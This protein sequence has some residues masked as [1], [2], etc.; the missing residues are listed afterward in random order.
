M[1]FV[2][3]PC[4]LSVCLFW[5]EQE[6]VCSILSSYS[7]F[8]WHPF[9]Y[10]ALFGCHTCIRSFIFF[11]FIFYLDLNEDRLKKHWLRPSIN[12]YSAHLCIFCRCISLSLPISPSVQCILIICSHCF[13]T[14]LYLVYPTFSLFIYI[15]LYY[16][17][18]YFLTLS[19]S[20]EYFSRSHLDID[21]TL[22]FLQSTIFF[23]QLSYTVSIF[24]KKK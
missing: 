5:F 23:F 15:F 4:A 10:I 11:I 6:R 3:F 17:F 19:S 7:D 18:L 22:C 1:H 14:K 24:W 21:I 9:F 16:I 2:Y 12:A 20:L 13:R 8:L